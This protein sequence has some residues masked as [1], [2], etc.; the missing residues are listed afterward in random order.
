MWH[1]TLSKFDPLEQN[2]LLSKVV[3]RHQPDHQ[4][5][6]VIVYLSLGGC[7]ST[8]GGLLGFFWFLFNG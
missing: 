5:V 8:I 7:R 6:D 2:H 3:V 4:L 1:Y